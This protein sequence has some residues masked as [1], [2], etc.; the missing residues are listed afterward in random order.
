M[1]L[2]G[3]VANDYE[4]DDEILRI[5]APLPDRTVLDRINDRFGSY[6]LP[7][8]YPEGSPLHPSYPSGHATI[9]GACV[10]IL[11]A[12][13]DEDFDI[14]NP[15]M[16]DPALDGT[17]LVDYS[18]TLKVGHELNKLASNI[19]I[20]RNMAG[21]HYRSDYL[22]GVLLGEKVAI[23]ILEDQADTYNEDF[24]IRF[25]KFNG[26]TKNIRN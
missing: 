24:S 22:Q 6:L 26:E 12:H 8:A 16:L 13:F 1:T 18:G 2:N 5:N 4:I 19:A 15:V 3:L 20:G 9:A 11:K 14:P 23:S 7:Q 25:T 10:T 17:G 21:L